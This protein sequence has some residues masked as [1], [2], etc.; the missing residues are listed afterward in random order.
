MNCIEKGYPSLKK[1]QKGTICKLLQKTNLKPFKVKY[2]LDSKDPHF[3]EKM[4]QV[5]LQYKKVQL[6]LEKQ[7][8]EKESNSLCPVKTSPQKQEWTVVSY[9]EKPGV[10]CIETKGQTNFPLSCHGANTHIS[11]DYEYIRHGTLSLLSGIDLLTGHV[12]MQIKERH[13]SKEFV[14]FLEELD[15]Y[16]EPN[17]KIEII[18]DNHSVHTSKETRM[19]LK[20]HTDRFEFT[21]TP[22]H[23]SWLNMIEMFFSKME[24]CFLKHLRVKSKDEFIKRMTAYIEELNDEPVI[25]RWKYK[26]D[27]VKEDCLLC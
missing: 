25:F 5:L 21:F 14:E 20:E 2:Y 9:D 7:E 22:T 4:T 8:E 26:M 6:Q 24:R 23:G 19:Y 12:H 10:Q 11:R 15:A 13:R 18:L 17:V 1:I 3:E 27:T 16:Y